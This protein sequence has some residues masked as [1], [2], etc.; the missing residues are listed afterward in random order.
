MTV[1]GSKLLIQIE[2]P[3]RLTTV[4]PQSQTSW[5][6]L[7]N[8][9]QEAVWVCIMIHR[10]WVCARVN[11]SP[12]VSDVGVRMTVH[13]RIQSRYFESTHVHIPYS[14]QC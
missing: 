14:L 8:V 1:E 9:D 10:V 13:Y 3:L 7:H 6:S 2:P 5:L 12:V 11:K 4:A